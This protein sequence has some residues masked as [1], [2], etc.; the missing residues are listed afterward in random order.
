MNGYGATVAEPALNAMGMTVENLSD[1]A[2]RK[3]M[4]VHVVA[5][6]VGIGA[7]AGVAK[8]L[9]DLPLATLLFVGYGAALA[10]TAF[11][12]EEI[13]NVAWDSA[14]VTTGPVT[15]PL[16][17]PELPHATNTHNKIMAYAKRTS[18]HLL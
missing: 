15:V 1:G 9:F 7:A 11:S 5:A 12:R 10:L 6:G 8:I 18:F 13:V 16:L 2:F 4:L 3:R 14:G 17:L